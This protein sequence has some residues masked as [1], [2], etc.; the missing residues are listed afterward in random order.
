ML[1]LTRYLNFAAASTWRGGPHGRFLR[2][3]VHTLYIRSTMAHGFSRLKGFNY[4]CWWIWGRLLA[5]FLAWALNWMVSFQGYSAWKEV[6]NKRHKEQ[7]RKVYWSYFLAIHYLWFWLVSRTKWLIGLTF[8]INED[9]H[10]YLKYLPMS[11]AD[12]YHFENL[13]MFLVVVTLYFDGQ[14]TLI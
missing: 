11:S 13:Q 8:Y 10:L 7:M 14:L 12:W 4:S 6:Q 9:L 1:M 3:A 5:L 2:P